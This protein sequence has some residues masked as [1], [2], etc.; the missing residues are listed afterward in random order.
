MFVFIYFVL[1]VLVGWL[2][3]HKEIGFVGF[4]LLSLLI[5]P[6]A[7]FLILLIAHDR[8]T[9]DRPSRQPVKRA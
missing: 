7:T 4:L 5:T 8:R 9:E 2:G 1:A 3:R 6:V